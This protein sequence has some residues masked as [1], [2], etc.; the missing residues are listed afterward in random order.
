MIEII[1]FQKI[2]SGRFRKLL[3]ELDNV[4]CLYRKI[5]EKIKSVINNHW[6]HLSLYI[7][8]EENKSKRDVLTHDNHLNYSMCIYGLDNKGNKYYKF[9]S[10]AGDDMWLFTDT[11]ITTISYIF[12]DTIPILTDFYIQNC[13]KPEN[14]SDKEISIKREILMSE[15]M[16]SCV[17]K[18]EDTISKPIQISK[19][20]KYE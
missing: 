9:P 2:Q 7:S 6:E 20:K 16:K 10:E 13:N 5:T 12:E 8:D 3:K 19:K 15:T 17:F 11:S 4:S 18:I 14:L 1:F